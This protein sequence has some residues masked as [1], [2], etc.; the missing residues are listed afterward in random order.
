MRFLLVILVCVISAIPFFAKADGELTDAEIQSIQAKEEC[1]NRIMNLSDEDLKT[2]NP[3]KV[4]SACQSFPLS[5]DV[6]VQVLA[7]M[8][9]P[10]IIIPLDIYSGLTQKKHGLNIDSPLLTVATPLHNVMYSINIFFLSFLLV[11]TLVVFFIL[12][13]QFQKSGK[14]LSFREWLSKQGASQAFAILLSLPVFGWMTPIQLLALVI[15]IMLGYVAKLAVTILLLAAFFGDTGSEIKKDISKE[16]SVDFGRTVMLYNC[17]IERRETLLEQIQTN[18]GSKRQEDLEANP[19]YNCLT[20]APLGVSKKEVIS[21]GVNDILVAYTPKTLGHTQNCIDGY[22]S[23]LSSW[24]VEEPQK[25]GVLN[26]TLPKNSAYP[27]SVNNA[28][29][30]YSN[31]NIEEIE[32]DLALMVHQFKC[33][34]NNKVPTYQNNLIPSCLRTRKNGDG[35]SYGFIANPV[36]KDMELT[37]YN[38]PLTE[39]SREGFSSQVKTSLS[40]LSESISSNT[41][42][43]KT[44]LGDLL[45]NDDDSLSVGTQEKIEALEERVNGYVENSDE[46]TTSGLGVSEHDVN[47]VVNNIQRGAWTASSLFFGKLSDGL[48]EKVI[49][50][51]LRDVYSV[52][53]QDDEGFLN[54]DLLVLLSMQGLTGTGGVGELVESYITPSVILPRMGLY[55]ENLDCW[56][57]QVDCMTP[58][59]NP[60]T[61]LAERGAWLIDRAS[62]QFIGTTI[63]QQAS[64]FVFSLSDRD[65]YGRFMILE[66]L[67][68]L[69][70]I[71]VIIG[72]VLAVF[73]PG[74]PFLKLVAVLVNWVYDVFREL[75]GIQIK[76]TFSAF[77]D[78]GNQLVGQDVREALRRLVG[79]GLY[80]LFIVVGLVSMFLMFSFLFSLDIFL[81]GIL[82]KTVSWNGGASGVHEMVLFVI[83]DVI[84]AILLF[85]QVKRCTTYIEKIPQALANEY[86]IK[87]TSSDGVVDESVR[88]VQSQVLTGVSDLLHKLN[89]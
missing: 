65:K 84:I 7:A 19:L 32:R 49:I 22:K 62:L 51:A 59:L 74:I 63:L 82:S 70:F 28:I 72:I 29:S 33:R 88:Y 1:R 16:L 54:S 78:H 55:E 21:E 39:T 67:G 18:V 8:I 58:P 10:D 73:I 15:I 66:T 71:Y 17:D 11:G 83:F 87:V 86:N 64:K 80:F 31:P 14:K 24:G 36:T 25:C 6:F 37:Y 5:D 85:I 38:T 30:L 52:S 53:N 40:T 57:N 75:I 35:Y 20:K 44:H 3:N 61:Y 23:L 77:G 47:F 13:F 89:K 81:I 9:G 43:L 12:L 41:V 50:N 76:I 79:L 26:F 46:E 27:G 4:I 60:F 2:L 48:E 34:T 68:G 42:A 56:A 69:Q 45:V